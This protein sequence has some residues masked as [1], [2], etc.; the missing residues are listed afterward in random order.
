MC[1]IFNFKRNSSSKTE[2]E[3]QL[4]EALLQ[5]ELLETK[6]LEIQELLNSP[7]YSPENI[8]EKSDAEE[9]DT[10]VPE[11][12]ESVE[13]IKKL[14]S[15]I[16]SLNDENTRLKNEL[17]K[18]NENGSESIILNEIHKISS[19][20][21]E[22]NE[23]LQENDYLRKKLDEKQDRLEYITHNCQED[24]YRKDKGRLINRTIYQMDLIRDVIYDFD[25]EHN[26]DMSDSVTF[27]RQQFLE[28]IT[29]MEATLRAE[30]VECIRSG[31]DGS[32]LNLELQE[33]IDVVLTDTPE[34]DG[35]V[36]RSVHP[37]Y[38]WKL[39]YILKAKVKD[40]GSIVKD[41]DFLIRPEQVITYKL[42]K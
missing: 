28:I 19:M 1:P 9:T 2:L 15:D 30:Y 12:D 34:L 32:T 26:E 37:G 25:K 6:I 33:V 8:D 23:I 42:N 4:N 24:R 16:K 40:D 29:Y 31:E 38:S 7:E 10:I 11:S 22:R 20:L 17:D 14:Q 13:L 39:P 36:H 27:L 18:T 3:K 5:K 35:K 21:S 41:Y